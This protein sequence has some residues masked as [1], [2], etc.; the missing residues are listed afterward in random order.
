[1]P[2]VTDYSRGTVHR[3]TSARQPYESLLQCLAVHQCDFSATWRIHDLGV[4][5][6]VILFG[7]APHRIE[8]QAGAI[9]RSQLIFG[10]IGVGVIDIAEQV[11]VVIESAHREKPVLGAVKTGLE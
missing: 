1:M 9:D 4:R 5:R 11:A 2:I 6:A 8:R 7:H 3:S 10:V